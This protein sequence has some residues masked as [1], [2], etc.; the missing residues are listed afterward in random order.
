[1]CVVGGVEEPPAERDPVDVGINAR[2]AQLAADSV[3]WLMRRLGPILATQHV[4]KPLLDG[5]HRCLNTT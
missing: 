1:M 4:V 5:L 2:I 3:C